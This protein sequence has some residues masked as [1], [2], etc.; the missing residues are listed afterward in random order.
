MYCWIII[1]FESLK[2]FF[3]RLYSSIS[4]KNTADDWH[5][6]GIYKFYQNLLLWLRCSF[7]KCI[8]TSKLLCNFKALQESM[9]IKRGP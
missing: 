1:L 4:D 5:P 3:T 8:C 2:D 9:D 6:A 7:Q